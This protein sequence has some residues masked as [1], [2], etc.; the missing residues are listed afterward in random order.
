MA[1]VYKVS[2]PDAQAMA[3]QWYALVPKSVNLYSLSPAA[4][5]SAVNHWAT[6]IQQDGSNS[7]F[8]DFSNSIAKQHGPTAAAELASNAALQ[9]KQTGLPPWTPAQGAVNGQYPGTNTKSVGA[10]IGTALTSPVGKIVEGVIAG[11]IDVVS[12]GALTPLTT[13]GLGI[14]QGAGAAVQP[15]ANFG[16]IAG[17]ALG[18]AGEGAL[19][20][21]G[22]GALN[23]LTGGALESATAGLPSAA[24]MSPGALSSVANATSG[25]SVAPSVVGLPGAAAIGT[26]VNAAKTVAGVGGVAG[27][28]G[29][30]PNSSSGVTNL[31]N[32]LGTTIPLIAGATNAANL[33]AQAQQYAQDAVNT[34]T[35]Q[36][37]AEQPLRDA[38]MAGLLNPSTP[39]PGLPAIQA[40]ATAAGKGNP[41]ATPLPV[42]SPTAPPAPSAAQGLPTPTPVSTSPTSPTIAA[43][44][45]PITPPPTG[46]PQATAVGG[47]GAGNGLNPQLQAI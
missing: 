15:G 22:A 29:A 34:D 36:Y 9:T 24:S 2:Q 21:L 42:N 41:F 45:K 1:T 17:A 33:Q 47:G 38:G 10:E 19:A 44:P 35:Q 8:Q 20:G 7:A 6:E 5:T 26:G 28:S 16:S 14:L 39:A 31:L 30:P 25:T 23:S 32:G 18:G 43:Q 37:A 40:L 13:A 4:V 27:A 3:E 11:A 12:G 46:L